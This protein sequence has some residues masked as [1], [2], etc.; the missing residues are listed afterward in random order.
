MFEDIEN[1]SPHISGYHLIIEK[2][3][4]RVVQSYVV[5][6]RLSRT[7]GGGNDGPGIR[8]TFLLLLL[9][10]L[11]LPPE[12]AKETA[13]A[14]PTTRTLISHPPH[15]RMPRRRKLPP[16][17]QHRA[18][19][20]TRLDESRGSPPPSSSPSSPTPYPHT[21]PRKRVSILRNTLDDT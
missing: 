13:A 15:P 14:S 11:L 9:I 20:P 21:P 4:L 1:Y 6:P 16:P 7:D 3:S 18:L 8:D 10:I 12:A 17:T 19:F 2:K 5:H